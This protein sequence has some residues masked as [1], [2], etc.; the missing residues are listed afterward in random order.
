VKNP[1]KST[2]RLKLLGQELELPQLDGQGRKQAAA[3]LEVLTGL[4]TPQQAAQA[5]NLSLPTYFKLETRALRGL[6]FACCAL[7]PGRQP[8]LAP[9][10][11]QAQA[12]V[13]DLQRQLVRYQALLRTAR[14]SMGLAHAVEPKPAAGA[15]RKVK[16][17]SVR[18]LRVVKALSQAPAVSTPAAEPPASVPHGPEVLPALGQVTA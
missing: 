15:K 1:T 11:R 14:H 4:R 5:L 9:Q 3:V 18:A 17:P 12:K 6:V 13:S 7:P 8:T 16:K 2:T 10:L